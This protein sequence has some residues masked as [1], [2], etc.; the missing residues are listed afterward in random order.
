MRVGFGDGDGG[1]WGQTN[2]LLNCGR[3]F[4]FCNVIFKLQLKA[5]QCRN[6]NQR[7]APAP[8][9]RATSNKA[10]IATAT[11]MAM[12]MARA[13]H[14]HNEKKRIWNEWTN[15]SEK[16]KMQ[17][18]QWICMNNWAFVLFLFGSIWKK[19]KTQAAD[20]GATA[21]QHSKWYTFD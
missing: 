12:A 7:F 8:Q 19:L 13:K 18:N 11:T 9:L 16:N 17:L 10:I 15:E 3:S 21:E 6:G 2:R 20:G 4:L 1:G 5:Q 14:N